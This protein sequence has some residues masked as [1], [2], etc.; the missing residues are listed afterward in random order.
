[1]SNKWGIVENTNFQLGPVFGGKVRLYHV[2]FLEGEAL[3]RFRKW[4][5]AF[6]TKKK[7]VADDP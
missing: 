7:K 3:K 2:A 4:I 6:V 1:V 5:S